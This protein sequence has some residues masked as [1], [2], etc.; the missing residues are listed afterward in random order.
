MLTAAVTGSPLNAKYGTAIDRESAYE[1]LAARRVDAPA[2]AEPAGGE[3]KAA[4][5]ARVAE[6]ER[7]HACAD[8][9]V[10]PTTWPHPPTTV[11]RP[12]GSVR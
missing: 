5:E 12:V 9:A 2:V 3:R 4:E 1:L 7:R 8:R 6:E 11:C 10:P